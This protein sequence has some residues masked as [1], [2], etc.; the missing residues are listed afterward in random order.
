LIYDG[1]V[2]RGGLGRVVAVALLTGCALHAPIEQRTTQGPGAQELWAWRMRAQLGREPSFDERRHFDDQLEGRIS[3]YL[4]RHP[5]DANALEVSTFRFARQ[6]SVGMSQEQVAILLGPPLARTS[7]GADMEKRARRFWPDI[8]GR[9]RHAWT[10]PLGW[11]VYFGDE[12]RVVDLTQF[13][14]P[15]GAEGS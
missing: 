2:N 6:V 4:A 1:R 12:E 8:R 7:D 10:Y 3:R 14:A 15:G 11:T 13:L 9:A 5:E